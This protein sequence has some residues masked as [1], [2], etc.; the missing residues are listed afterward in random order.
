MLNK[1][2]RMILRSM[3]EYSPVKYSSKPPIK[4][5][6]TLLNEIREQIVC[7]KNLIAAAVS[8]DVDN[9]DFSDICLLRYKLT[10]FLDAEPMISGLPPKK[11][12]IMYSHGYSASENYTYKNYFEM[13]QDKIISERYIITGSIIFSNEMVS[14]QSLTIRDIDFNSHVEHTLAL[15]N[16]LCYHKDAFLSIFSKN[17]ELLRYIWLA[18][19]VLSVIH[20][21]LEE[22]QR[23]GY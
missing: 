22:F 23:Y 3:K 8:D 9:I 5:K 1:T 4:S 11:K 10:E 19:T 12:L 17:E 21:M 14:L 16:S 13:M 18:D 2:N 6:K 15:W 7:F 20:Y